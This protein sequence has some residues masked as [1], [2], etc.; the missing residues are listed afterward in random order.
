V[1]RE[2]S[3]PPLSTEWIGQVTGYIYKGLILDPQI[4]QGKKELTTIVRWGGGKIRVTLTIKF[5]KAILLLPTFI[6]I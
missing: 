3:L 4:S 1:S 2:Q 5:N 6:Y